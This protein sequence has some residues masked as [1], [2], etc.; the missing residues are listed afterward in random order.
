[1]RGIPTG[2]APE[3]GAGKLG[4]GGWVAIAVGIITSL[5]VAIG[6]GSDPETSAYTICFSDADRNI[7]LRNTEISIEVLRA[8]E[9]PMMLAADSNG[10]VRF[11]LQENRVRFVVRAPYFKTDTITRFLDP[12]RGSE[13][14]PLRTDDYALM[15]HYFSNSKVED[16]KARRRTLNTMFHEQARIVQVY[17]DRKS[18]ME[19]YNKQEF[20]QKLTMPLQ[21]LRNIEVLDVRYRGEQIVSMRFIQQ[22]P[23][24]P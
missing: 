11:D 17:S 2:A 5:W 14:I 9:S 7:L 24:R 18:G 6:S 1:V 16:W 3:R 20:I 8:G 10:C 13:D 21:S 22:T 23:D 19:L 4:Y 15:M 12:D